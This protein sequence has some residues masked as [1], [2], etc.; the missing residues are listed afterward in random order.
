MHPA[1]KPQSVNT[2]N[3][4]SE[5]RPIA[6]LARILLN[7]LSETQPDAF[8]DIVDQVQTSGHGSVDLSKYS[9]SISSD[10]KRKG[11]IMAVLS[12]AGTAW[13]GFDFGDRS[14]IIRDWRS[15]IVVALP[16]TMDIPE[17][18]RMK[19]LKTGGDGTLLGHIYTTGLP[20]IDALRVDKV[21]EH[22]G[23][24]LLHNGDEQEV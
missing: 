10:A 4:S 17:V 21:S 16:S 12:A 6:R 5:K 23:D 22:S 19:L 18:L 15:T 14:P 1:A 2:R 8:Q 3:T 24:L 20:E 7:H 13:R 11:E 9:L